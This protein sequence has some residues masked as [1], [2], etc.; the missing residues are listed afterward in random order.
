LNKYKKLISSDSKPKLCIN[1][2]IKGLLHKQVIVPIN[3]DN[4]RKFIKDS[5]TYIIKINR[6]LKSIKSNVMA[7]FIQINNKGIV[8]STNNVASPLDLQEIKRCVK[9]SLC[10][11]ADQINFLRLLQSKLYLKIVSIPYLTKQSNTCLFSD[12]IEKILKSN[13]IFN[14]I[15]LASKLRVIK[16]S[17]KSDMSIV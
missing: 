1:I 3:I 16:I 12:N 5:S 17:P 4:A 6:A 2:T 14:D 7:D 9:N 8:I 15:V 11:E 10:V 13:H